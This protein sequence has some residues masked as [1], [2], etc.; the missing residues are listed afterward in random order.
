MD[1]L[2][3][4]HGHPLR[5]GIPRAM[6]Y[7]YLYP[8]L[9]TL[10][11]ELGAIPV[12]S[13]PTTKR[14]MERM[15]VCPTDE[16]CLAVK[17][18]FGHA[19]L[20]ASREDIDLV[21]VPVIAQVADTACCPKFIGI[22]DMVRHGLR[23]PETRIITPIINFSANDH[24]LQK[25][26]TPLAHRLG[27]TDRARLRRAIQQARTAQQRYSALCIAEQ[28]TTPEAYHWLETDTPPAVA[29]SPPKGPVIAVIGHPYVIYESVS[30]GMI[31]RLRGCGRVITAEMVDPRLALQAMAGVREGE[32]MWPFEAIL[33]GAT[34]HLLQQQQIDK[35]ILV[36]SFECGPESII[37]S[38]IEEEAERHGIP[39]M[40]LALDEHS[41]EAGLVTR[42]EAFM[43]TEKLEHVHAEVAAFPTPHLLTRQEVVIGFPSMGNL[44]VVVHA[45]LE[46]LGVRTIPT[47]RTTKRCIE[48]GRELAPEFAC[49]PFTATLGQLRYQLEQGANTLLMV[50]GKQYC[51]LGWYAQVQEKLLRRLGFDFQL[52]VID[53]P[54]PLH[55]K[56]GP[57]VA[58]LHSVTG[59]ASW[60]R[61]LRALYVAYR[62]LVALDHAEMLAHRLRAFERN[63]GVTDRL[64]M[65]FQRQIIRCHDLTMLRRV[66]R[67][68]AEEAGSI[69]TEDTHP[70]RIRIAGEIWVILE[71]SAT[72]HVERWL[73]THADPRVWV[74][75]EHST[76]AW[77][78]GHI[79]R[80]RAA[81]AREECVV[82]AAQPWLGHKVGGHGQHTIGQMALAP[83]EGMDGILHIFPF[84][85]MPEIIAQIILVRMSEELDL[86]VLTYIV[87]EQMGEAGM[88][89]R[90]ESFLDVLA[91]RRYGRTKL[92]TT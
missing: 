1:D 47:P 38:Y 86:P 6:G 76:S 57:F 79:L 90:L 18:T 64:L 77:F 33:L 15:E 92:V 2:A 78:D 87:S 50:G 65:Q 83:R 54:F 62:Q 63:Q 28:V 69:E 48:L 42:L 84:T 82:A 80:R 35:L 51:R 39:L 49:F 11:L 13:P 71:Q 68:F 19:D 17:L 12:V 58:M 88:E 14:V 56:W 89:T 20:L 43:D 36:G 53:S 85:C 81:L 30:Q 40:L 9:R 31:E 41:G 61:I 74:E 23:L 59:G 7:Y 5:I 24:T 55:E 29:T 66:E 22:G 60:S 25:A 52:I 45:F 72:R 10:L 70:L 4:Q 46:S 67:D 37:E 73:G 16:P 75:R 34:L 44:D 26:L 21:C 3:Q 32:R 8:F 91:E 27:V